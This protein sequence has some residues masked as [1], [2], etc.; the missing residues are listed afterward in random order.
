M[1]NNIYLEKVQHYIEEIEECIKGTK[2]IASGVIGEN[3]LDIDLCFC[4]L[5]D[6]S[7][8]LADGFIPMVKNR[9]L[10]CA[11]ALLRLQ[12]DNCLRLYALYI[13]DDESAVVT[14]L[15]NGDKIDKLKD[16]KGNQMRDT[17]L[18]N[19]LGSIDPKLPIVYENASG[20]IHFSEK[21]I[22]QSIYDCSDHSIKFQVGGELSEK[23]NESL[24]E[25]AAAYLHFFRLFLEIM[26]SEVDWKKNFDKGMEE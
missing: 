10:T 4:G 22:Y 15:L 8:R 3:I 13:A 25:C 20:F 19:E 14:A 16:K 24:I 12:L 23:R 5:L 26:K 6:R 7:I 1:N 11:G 2:A 18:K 17:Y 21:A 9:N